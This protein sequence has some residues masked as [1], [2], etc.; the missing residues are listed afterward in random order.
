[1][2]RRYRTALPEGMEWPDTGCDVAPACLSCPLPECRYERH[3]G[4]AQM[5]TAR[6][7]AAAVRLRDEGLTPVQIAERIGRKK[8]TV[9]RLL[10]EAIA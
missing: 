1:M 5:Q 2:T 10:A 3:R 6:M 7:R 4:L 9:Y 8:R